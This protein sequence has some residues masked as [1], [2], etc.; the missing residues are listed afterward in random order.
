M[1]YGEALGSEHRVGSTIIRSGLSDREESA[2]L[3]TPERLGDD[4]GNCTGYCRRRLRSRQ[5]RYTWEKGRMNLKKKA[6]YIF[7]CK[8]RDYV[9]WKFYNLS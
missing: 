3:R 7:L 2:S 4:G 8:F 5:S 9:S 6:F 1:R